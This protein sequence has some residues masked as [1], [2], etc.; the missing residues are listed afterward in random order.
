MQSKTV[1][2]RWLERWRQEGVCSAA[3]QPGTL[4]GRREKAPAGKAEGV[5]DDH[6]SLASVLSLKAVRVGGPGAT[7]ASPVPGRPQPCCLGRGAGGGTQGA[8]VAP[9]T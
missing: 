6:R 2:T 5:W 1:G 4:P 8:T 3:V 9:P 7:A